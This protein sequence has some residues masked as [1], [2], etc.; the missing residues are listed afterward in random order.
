MISKTFPLLLTLSAVPALAVTETFSSVTAAVI[1]DND[2]GGLVQTLTP[3]TTLATVGNVTV[4]L[5]TSG[6]WNGDLYAYLFHDDTIAV[7]V[8]R[9]G[10]T[11]AQPDGSFTSGLDITLTDIALTDV[12]FATDV[13]GHFISGNYQPDGRV[14]H[15][16]SSLDTSLRAP[17][18]SQYIGGPAAGAWQLFIADVAAGDQATLLGWSITLS[19]VTVPEPATAALLAGAV[20]LLLVRRRPARD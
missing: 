8:N 4:T 13:F 3:A 2:L 17:S 5:K 14:V 15:P 10:R 7:L 9:I 18:L 12:H 16:N 11:A 19:D 1:P 6:G 20:A